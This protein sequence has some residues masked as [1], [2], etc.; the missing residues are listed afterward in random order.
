M[1]KWEDRGYT[2]MLHVAG[3]HDC[4]TNPVVWKLHSSSRG[5]AKQKVAAR[6]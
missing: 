1:H 5:A 6:L 3:P 4:G 2:A